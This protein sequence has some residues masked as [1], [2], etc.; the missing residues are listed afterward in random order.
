M[1]LFNIDSRNKTEN[2]EQC[3][4]RKR[5]QLGSPEK[6]EN[7]PLHHSSDYT[8]HFNQHSMLYLFC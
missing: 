5:P 1:G 8:V 7:I 4:R 2:D 6:K 3:G